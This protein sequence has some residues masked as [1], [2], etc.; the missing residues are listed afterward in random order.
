[1]HLRISVFLDTP[2][3]AQPKTELSTCGVT[4]PVFV[5][6][7]FKR[8]GCS[9]ERFSLL[10]LGFRGRPFVFHLIITFVW[11]LAQQPF[12]SSCRKE[13]LR[14]AAQLLVLG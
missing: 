11:H 6:D 12:C 4:P 7:V 8:R 9:T 14:I 13:D 10:R 1:M 3:A 2:D 5:V